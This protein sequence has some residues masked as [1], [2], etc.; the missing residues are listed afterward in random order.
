MKRILAQHNWRY[1]TKPWPQGCAPAT[2]YVAYL[3]DDCSK[4]PLQLTND[5]TEDSKV[6]CKLGGIHIHGI[7]VQLLELLSSCL[8]VCEDLLHAVSQCFALHSPQTTQQ[9]GKKPL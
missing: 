9:S 4:A 3:C 1:P 6:I 8:K 5:P 2:V 7:I